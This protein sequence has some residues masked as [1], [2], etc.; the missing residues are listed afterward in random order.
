MFIAHLPSGYIAGCFLTEQC[1]PQ[2]KRAILWS[3]MIG[4]VLP[5]LDMFYFYLVDNGR[6]LHHTYWTHLPVFWVAMLFATMALAAIL[7]SRFLAIIAGSFIGGVFLHLLLDTPF[8]GI[9]W[10][11]PLS[12]HNFHFVTVPATRAWWVWSFVFHWTFLC[13]IAICAWAA[14]L[15][16]GRRSR[17]LP[18]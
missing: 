3:V 18:K 16:F 11:Y 2:H 17:A 14:V 13:E 15:Y 5:D 9:A 6:H 1:L 12:N 4:S 10:L 8:A 7:R